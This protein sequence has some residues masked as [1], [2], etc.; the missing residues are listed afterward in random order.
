VSG[1]AE[2]LLDKPADNTVDK[3]GGSGEALDEILRIGIDAQSSDT[4]PLS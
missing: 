3:E 4:N 2:L 1:M